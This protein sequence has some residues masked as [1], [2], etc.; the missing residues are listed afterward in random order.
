MSDLAERLAKL[1]PDKRNLLLQK[2]R[3]TKQEPGQGA[4]AQAGERR[5]M[6][7]DG[8]FILR[9]GRIGDLSSL[10]FHLWPRKP[11]RPKEVQ[12]QICATSLNFRDV[13]IALGLYPTPPGVTP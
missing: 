5:F 8:N 3:Q 1:S 10:K 7:E 9:V 11:L 6:P 13:L 4:S 2:I 12:I